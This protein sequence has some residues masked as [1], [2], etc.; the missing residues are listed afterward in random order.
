M[1]TMSPVLSCG[2]QLNENH[3]FAPGMVSGW[4]LTSA[5]NGDGTKVFDLSGNG[6]DGN[7]VNTPHW[8]PDGVAFEYADADSIDTINTVNSCA[9][10]TIFAGIW[11]DGHG[12]G[13][14]ENIVGFHDGSAG[15]KR[16][17]LK[18]DD[19]IYFAVYDGGGKTT[20]APASALTAGHHTVA[21]TADGTTAR[22][23]IDGLEVGSVAAGNT[24]ASYSGPGIRIGE[25]PLRGAFQS[26]VKFVYVWDHGKTAAEIEWLHREHFAMF[27]DQAWLAWLAAAQEVGVGVA[28]T[29]ALYGPLHGPLAGPI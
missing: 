28:P 23:Y 8:V 6:N 21:G 4:I 11:Y 9:H 17:V 15:G 25:T 18:T 26:V 20:S 29:G 22:C 5:V 7:F 10:V 24:Y 3:L 1:N 19:K 12:P 16:I 27:V 14:T 2:V 13:A